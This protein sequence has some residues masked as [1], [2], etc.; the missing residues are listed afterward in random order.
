M[1]QYTYAILGAGRQGTAAA[2]DLA[3][4]GEAQRIIMADIHEES[5]AQAAQRINQLVG[6]EVAMAQPLDVSD[7]SALVQTL[8][9]VNVARSAVPYTLHVV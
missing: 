9:G 5:V 8:Q 1:S 4:F 3:L 6:R 7:L 2:Y